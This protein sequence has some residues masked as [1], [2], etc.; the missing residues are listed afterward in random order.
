MIRSRIGAKHPSAPTSSVRKNPHKGPHDFLRVGRGAWWTGGVTELP[1]LRIQRVRSP[2]RLFREKTHRPAI[3]GATRRISVQPGLQPQVQA[4]LCRSTGRMARVRFPSST[5]RPTLALPCEYPQ[6]KGFSAAK[7][8]PR[9]HTPENGPG[10]GPNRTPPAA[11][12][13]EFSWLARANYGEPIRRR[14]GRGPGAVAGGHV[15]PGGALADTPVGS[16]TSSTAHWASVR[17]PRSRQDEVGTRPPV[18][19]D[20]LGR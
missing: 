16:S 1:P 12:L 17:S 11:P 7:G 10:S 14:R 5:P 15:A 20:L 2:S 4:C 13:R 3:D 19:K 8:S 18:L 9:A 6:R